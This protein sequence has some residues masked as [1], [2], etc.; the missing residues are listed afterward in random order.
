MECVCTSA[1]VKNRVPD[2][3]E[4]QWL[5]GQYI[6]V[7]FG[8]YKNSPTYIQSIFLFESS[9]ILTLS[10]N[11]FYTNNNVFFGKTSEPNSLLLYKV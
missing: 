4:N 3:L 7:V 1:G 11:F 8:N 9:V 2:S 10:W 5:V 6:L